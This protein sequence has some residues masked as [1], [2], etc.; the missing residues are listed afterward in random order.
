VHH[1]L[2]NGDRRKVALHLHNYQNYSASSS[3]ELA[4]LLA[5]NPLRN[6]GAMMDKA[7]PSHIVAVP[8]CPGPLYFGDNFF[9]HF[10]RLFAK[11]IYVI[12][13]QSFSENMLAISYR[14]LVSRS[15]K[16]ETA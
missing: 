13:V 9:R 4:I 16:I 1:Y 6:T 5:K 14:R 2:A 3:H 7:G 15:N 11:T 10:K 12:A 8:A